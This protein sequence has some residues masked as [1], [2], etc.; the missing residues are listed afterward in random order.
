[1]VRKS[2]SF[3]KSWSRWTSKSH[4]N[5]KQVE[6]LAIWKR[7]P[8]IEKAEE[9]PVWKSG[10]L[11]PAFCCAKIF[12]N[13]RFYWSLQHFTLCAYCSLI[14]KSIEFSDKLSKIETLIVSLDCFSRTSC[15]LH[16]GNMFHLSDF[17][18]QIVAFS[19]DQCSTWINF[20]NKPVSLPGEHFPLDLFCVTTCCLVA[21]S[22]F[23]LA[24]FVRQL[25]PYPDPNWLIFS[26]NKP[27]AKTASNGWW[28]RA[29]NSLCIFFICT[30]FLG[31]QRVHFFLNDCSVFWICE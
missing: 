18:S 31:N 22:L 8:S 6:Q 9:H 4:Q 14:S 29:S 11:W 3:Q 30:S 5:W 21:G 20:P 7:A 10:L 2:I 27:K 1:M 13:G 25:S 19:Q 15:F 23:Q 26:E 17:L 28:R 16:Q 24:T 12:L